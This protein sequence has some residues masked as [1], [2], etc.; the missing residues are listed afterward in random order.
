[1]HWT[2][3][4]NCGEPNDETLHKTEQERTTDTHGDMDETPK[5]LISEKKRH[6]RWQTIWFH[7]H[8]TLEGQGLELRTD[9]RG[10][11]GKFGGWW[12]CFN[13]VYVGL[14][15][16][17]PLQNNWSVGLKWMHYTVWNYT[18]TKWL[19]TKKNQRSPT[20]FLH[21]NHNM[22]SAY[23]FSKLYNYCIQNINHDI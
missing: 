4:Q 7:L 11:K 21:F 23:N 12:I 9:H 18:W 17:I 3:K 8:D 14:Y 10:T 20:T 13:L 22:K 1:M 16:C 2:K 6:K 19:K 15:N 5:H